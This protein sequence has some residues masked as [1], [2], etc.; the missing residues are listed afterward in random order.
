MNST[1][2][3]VVKVEA[4]RECRNPSEHFTPDASMA[5]KRIVDVVGTHKD[6]AVIR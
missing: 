1:L 3:L 2:R 6:Y 4:A 5:G